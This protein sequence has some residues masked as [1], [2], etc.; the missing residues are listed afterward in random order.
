MVVRN[1]EPGRGVL[2]EDGTPTPSASSPAQGRCRLHRE[3]EDGGNRGNE[4]GGNYN[5][6]LSV[7]FSSQLTVLHEVA[8]LFVP[9][10]PV[11]GAVVF[12]YPL[13]LVTRE[14]GKLATA[15]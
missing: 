9:H 14:V 6:L 15:Q 5:S 11:F 2:S 3:G 8:E 7:N 4:C 13:Y 12:H 1:H 10:S